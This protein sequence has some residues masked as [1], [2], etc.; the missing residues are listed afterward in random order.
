MAQEEKRLLIIEAAVRRFGH[1][2]IAKTTMAEIAADLSMSKALL[3]YYF[4]DKNHLCAA[5]LEYVIDQSFS[6]ARPVLHAIRDCREAMLFI[7]D[8]RMAF[9]MNY[10]NLLEYSVGTPQQ[11][12]KEVLP[13][14]A[15]A[16][17]IQTQLFTSIL[18]R[19]IETGQLI[20][21][22]V[23]EISNMLLYSIE[24]MRFSILKNT[25]GLL[26]PAREEFESILELQKKMMLILLE[27]LSKKS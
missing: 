14:F 2:G 17:D 18:R 13:V 22:D 26:F 27:G 21:M 1:F 10:Y 19:G 24:G 9:V 12:P 25:G 11:M 23:E 3:Y 15:K 8:Q 7:L 4:P 5:A 6:N 16:R 20:E